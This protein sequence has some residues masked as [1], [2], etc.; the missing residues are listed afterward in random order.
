[1]KHKYCYLKIQFFIQ[2]IFSWIRGNPQTIHLL[3]CGN[4]RFFS[5]LFLE[6]P[7]IIFSLFRIPFPVKE[8][9]WISQATQSYI[10][11]T[12]NFYDVL[13]CIAGGKNNIFICLYP[14]SGFRPGF[15]LRVLF[16]W[17]S[18]LILWIKRLQA[19]NWHTILIAYI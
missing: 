10:S 18:F 7:R 12:A 2:V 16:L 3:F 11:I 15:L 6:I 9:F 17:I 5:P 19:I 8:Q 14:N 13:F 1:M 4:L